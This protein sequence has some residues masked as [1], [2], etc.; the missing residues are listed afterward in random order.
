MPREPLRGARAQAAAAQPSWARAPVRAPVVGGPG[1][2]ALASRPLPGM[3]RQPDESLR[4]QVPGIPS[5]IVRLD[6]AFLQQLNGPTIRSWGFYAIQ[7]FPYTAVTTLPTEALPMSSNASKAVGAVADTYTVAPGEVLIVTD[8]SFFAQTISAFGTVNVPPYSLYATL[9]L[10]LQ[11]NFASA[12]GE[13]IGFLVIGETSALGVA[14][15]RGLPAFAR[16]FKENTVISGSY[17]LSALPPMSLHSVGV[18]ASGF[19][20]PKNVFERVLRGGTE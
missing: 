3:D 2:S 18:R 16:Y 4:P 13:I 9:S 10:A 6:D 12:L 11:A 15:P 8:V 19:T 7:L 17:R 20:L 5:G 14:P 1:V